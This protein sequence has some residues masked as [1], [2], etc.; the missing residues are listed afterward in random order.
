MFVGFFVAFFYC[1][2]FTLLLFAFMPFLMITTILMSLAFKRQAMEGMKYYAQSA[3]Y[4]EQALLAIKV[5][6]TYGREVKESINYNKYLKRALISERR[7]IRIGAFGLACIWFGIFNFYGYAFYFAGYSRFKGFIDANGNIVTA[8]TIM[9]CIF[10][11]IMA[12]M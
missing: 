2:Q 7:K 6:Q 1:Y 10:C 8:G 9:I 4:A 12:S 11:I 3:G 5:V